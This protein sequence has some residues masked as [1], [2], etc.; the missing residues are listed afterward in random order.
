MTHSL[1]SSTIQ[2]LHALAKHGGW[3]STDDLAET[4]KQHRA[5]A[6]ARLLKCEVMG[7]IEHQEAQS[8]THEGGRRWFE[9]RLTPKGDRAVVEHAEPERPSKS[10]FR[11]TPASVFQLAQA[12]R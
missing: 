1:T 4:F 2:T 12:L 10:M 9:Y 7:F 3:C 6:R 8:I 5:T 11:F